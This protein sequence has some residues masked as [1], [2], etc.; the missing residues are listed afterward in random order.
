MFEHL[1]KEELKE[2]IKQLEAKQEKEFNKY[3]ERN[4]EKMKKL[5]EKK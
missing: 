2:R 4:I 3:R 5:L 1:S